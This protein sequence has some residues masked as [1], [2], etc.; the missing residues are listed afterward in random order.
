MAGNTSFTKLITTTLQNLPSLVTD[1]ISTNNALAYML[2]KRGNI[3]IVS[4]GRKFTHPLWY[5]INS[6]FNSYGETESISTAKQED[7]T[8]AEFPIKILAGSVVVSLFE[9][10]MNAGD[11]ER[12]I[13]L[14]EDT[15]TRG[16]LSMSD[17]LGKQVF[18]S[19][20]IDADFDGL[21][22]LINDSPSTQT[23]VGGIDASSS[24]NV[25]WRNQTGSAVSAFATSSEG[26]N[27]MAALLNSC[28]F[29]TSGPRL[30]VTTKTIYALYEA[31]LTSQI[32]Y[33]TTEL[34]DTKFMHLAYATMPV[35]FDDNCT[36]SRMFFIDTDNLW[37]QVLSRG[38]F[39]VTDMMQ[40]H[41][42]LLKNA[43]MYLFGNLTCGS[44]RT[45]GV[46]TITG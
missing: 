6:T 34:A 19:G 29:G 4:G 27:A 32:R 44:R 28:V 1:N 21:P 26:L 24:A 41:N 17:L 15:I 42:Q 7:L 13:A 31:A 40:S 20:S 23:D 35:V 37:L 9:E 36:A 43:L 2:Q 46:V 25:F 14:V 11:K 33:T 12:L 3:K 8:R 22:H 45:N 16:K 10:A 30:V 18:K 38:N 39:E 5:L